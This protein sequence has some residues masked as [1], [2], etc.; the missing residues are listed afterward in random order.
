MLLKGSWAKQNLSKMWL[1]EVVGHE[2]L[3]VLRISTQETVFLLLGCDEK[4][5]VFSR[6]FVSYI[7]DEVELCRAPRPICWKRKGHGKTQ[8]TLV[9][10]E[11]TEASGACLSSTECLDTSSLGLRRLLL[12]ALL[13]CIQIPGC[14][15][16]SDNI[17]SS[18]EALG[19]GH[20]RWM[21]A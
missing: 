11:K 3:Q 14:A 2:G 17:N 15:K 1:A 5:L 18:V 20:V 16:P 4:Q 12:L 9:K 8:L 13:S 7:F 10:G 6:Y 19:I 21:R